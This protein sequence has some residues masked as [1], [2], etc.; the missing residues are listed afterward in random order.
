ML[1]ARRTERNARK[2]PGN[3]NVEKLRII[4]LFEA[5]FN[6]SNKWLGRAIMLNTETLDLLAD[7][8]YRSNRQNAVVLQCLNKG[9]FY[10]LLRQ[11]KRPAALFEAKSCYNQI[12]LLAT[13]LCLCRLSAPINVVQSMKKTIHGMNHHI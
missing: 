13:A 6:A 2:I 1:L 11:W 8:Q 10:N 7:E 4:L 3:F 5:N 9:L 12:T